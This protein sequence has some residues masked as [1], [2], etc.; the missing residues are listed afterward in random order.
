MT[1]SNSNRLLAKR[2]LQRFVRALEPGDVKT[3]EDLTHAINA[4]LVYAGV[5]QAAR[6]DSGE[7]SSSFHAALKRN[8]LT[9]VK[10]K[11]EYEP[12]VIRTTDTD[13]LAMCKLLNDTSDNNRIM[14]RLL[15][16]GCIFKHDRPVNTCWMFNFVVYIM[17]I[18]AR[19]G[20]PGHAEKSWLAGFKCCNKHTRKDMQSTLKA[21]TTAWVDPANALLGNTTVKTRSG[22]TFVIDSFAIIVRPPDSPTTAAP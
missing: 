16:Y 18:D 1:V 9:V 20:I 22:R 17:D 3:S 7:N 5:R 10:W 15:G 4:T 19:T 21:Y 14:G 13:A 6:L 2:I 8:K 12:L 11:G